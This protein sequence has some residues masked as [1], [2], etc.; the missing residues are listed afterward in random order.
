MEHRARNIIPTSGSSQTKRVGGRKL[1]FYPDI[2][3]N[4]E[5]CDGG[6]QQCYDLMGR[7]AVQASKDEKVRSNL[8]KASREW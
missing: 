4:L 6:I 3:H 5:R 8:I 2:A 1:Q 7:Q